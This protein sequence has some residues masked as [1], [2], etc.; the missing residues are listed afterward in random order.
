METRLA[1]GAPLGAAAGFLLSAVGT[2]FGIVVGLIV[3]VVVLAGGL[4]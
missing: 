4:E 3:L 2:T 1:Q